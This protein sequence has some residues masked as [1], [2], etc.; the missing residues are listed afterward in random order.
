MACSEG[1]PIRLPTIHG[2]ELGAGPLQVL[3]AGNVSLEKR[4]AGKGHVA[5]IAKETLI[6]LHV[7][8]KDNALLWSMTHMRGEP[9]LDFAAQQNSRKLR[10]R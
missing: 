7:G 6:E 4:R 8:S 5:A 2:C 3:G 9:M 10:T 1:L